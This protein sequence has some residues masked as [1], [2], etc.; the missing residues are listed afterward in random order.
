M[1]QPKLYPKNAAPDTNTL[2]QKSYLA[3]TGYT[4]PIPCQLKLGHQ[5]PPW[6]TR[7]ETNYKGT[8]SPWAADPAKPIIDLCTY[9]HIQSGPA[10]LIYL[11]DDEHYMKTGRVGGRN[12]KKMSYLHGCIVLDWYYYYYYSCPPIKPNK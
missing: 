6:H 9:W 3:H 10:F 8:K 1:P 5:I 12:K 2:E 11:L 4:R 7:P